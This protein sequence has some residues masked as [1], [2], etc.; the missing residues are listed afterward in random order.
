MMLE[1]LHFEGMESEKQK[2]ILISK[3]CNSTD[4]AL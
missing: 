1:T 3:H 2:I 4:V